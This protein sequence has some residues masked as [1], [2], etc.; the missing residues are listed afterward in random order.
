MNQRWRKI[1]VSEYH[2]SQ[3]GALRTVCQS[4][5]M[6]VPSDSFGGL[7]PERKAAEDM[8][9]PFFTFVAVKIVMAQMEGLGRGDLGAYDPHGYASLQRFVEKH[10]L[11]RTNVD[12]WLK[13]L[14]EENDL[15]GRWCGV[16]VCVCIF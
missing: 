2:R 12:V 15:L 13:M 5:R 14:M 16:D 9:K 1:L 6:H 4:D 3:Y 7:S 10:P 8:L 11:T